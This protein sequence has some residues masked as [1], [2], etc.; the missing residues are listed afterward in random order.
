MLLDAG[1]G[2]S[3]ALTRHL[4]RDGAR[5]VVARLRAVY[6][7]HAHAD[8]VLGVPGVL[9]RRRN[10]APPLAVVGPEALHRWLR[11][12]AGGGRRGV[13]VRSMFRVVR[14]RRR[15]VSHPGGASRKRVP[16]AASARAEARRRSRSRS[17]SRSSS[18]SRRRRRRHHRRLPERFPRRLLDRLLLHLRSLRFPLRRRAQ[19]VRLH[20]LSLARLVCVDSSACPCDTAPTRPR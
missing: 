19:Q 17:S 4:G 12:G 13:A 11:A 20:I 10:D 2:V 7:S 18:R 6:V 8:H 14:G 5:D 16:D 1:E 15:A 3:G 9:F